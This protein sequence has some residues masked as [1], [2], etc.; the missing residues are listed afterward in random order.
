MLEAIGIEV[1][2]LVRVAIGGLELGEL[3]KGEPRKLSAAEKSRLD[4]AP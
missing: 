2:R 1:W 3:G 4:A